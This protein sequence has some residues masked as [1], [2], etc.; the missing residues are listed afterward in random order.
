MIKRLFDVLQVGLKIN[1]LAKH[2][3]LWNVHIDYDFRKTIKFQ[4][5]ARHYFI[6][7]QGFICKPGHSAEQDS[8]GGMIRLET[9]VELK[10][11][12]SSFSN[13]FFPHR[14]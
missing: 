14:K 7:K 3:Y 9:L 2:N 11:L 1:G 4:A 8:E 12:S 13:S 6:I 10:F 5:G